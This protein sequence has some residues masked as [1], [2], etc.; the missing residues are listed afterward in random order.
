MKLFIFVHPSDCF[1]CSALH[2]SRS[3]TVYCSCADDCSLL[4]FGFLA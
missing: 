3:T 1:T 2:K 4:R